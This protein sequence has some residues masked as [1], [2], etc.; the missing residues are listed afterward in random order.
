MGLS[1]S[2]ERF[3]EILDATNLNIDSPQMVLG[4]PGRTHIY[5][6]GLREKNPDRRVVGIENEPPAV[7]KKNAIRIGENTPRRDGTESTVL[8]ERFVR[9]ENSTLPLAWRNDL[10]DG[11]TNRERAPLDEGGLYIRTVCARRS[12]SG[13]PINSGPF[14]NHA[15]RLTSHRAIF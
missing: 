9:P 6:L 2:Y 15:G 14:A 11:V 10:S 13:I 1:A 8:S 12:D 7:L 4:D 5:S 3:S